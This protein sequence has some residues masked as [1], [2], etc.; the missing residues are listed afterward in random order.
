[1]SENENYDSNVSLPKDEL[2]PNLPKRKTQ[3]VEHI[4]EKTAGF[5]MRFWAFVVDILIVSALV[6]IVI[7]PLFHLFDWSLSEKNWYS[8]MSIVSGVFY[9][10]YFT[11]LTKYW[12]QTVGKMIFGLKVKGKNG[13]KLDWL[14]VLFRE[15][16]GRFISNKIPIIYLMVAFMP[17]NKGLNDIIADTMVVQEK[18]FVKRKKEVVTENPQVDDLDTQNSITPTV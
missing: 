7:N 17:N 4:E 14:T 2:V 6:G 10:A 16:V 11:I 9:Y 18:V 3:I 1:M 5:W 13:E 8:P 12:Q 15:L